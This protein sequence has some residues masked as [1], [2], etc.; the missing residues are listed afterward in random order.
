LRLEG[1]DVWCGLV[2]E[3]RPDP[4]RAGRKR[5]LVWHERPILPNYIFAT[6]NAREFYIAQG[7]KHVSPTMTMVPYSAE[8]DLRRF[9]DMTDAAYQKAQRAR[10]RG[11]EAPPA[12]S[13]GD[14]LEIVS[15][16][17]SGLLTKFRRVVEDAEGWHVVLDTDLG[18]VKA[19]PKDVRKAG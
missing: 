8:R 3:G 15:G 14:A 17:L 16:P 12:F 4:K 9:Q 13:E 7:L 6:M 10:E 19:S 2:L 18:E 1:I 5:G 11:E